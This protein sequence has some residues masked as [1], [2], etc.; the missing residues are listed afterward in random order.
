[1]ADEKEKCPVTPAIRVLKAAAA[2][3]AGML[4]DY[5]ERA[6][7]TRIAEVFGVDEHQVIKTLVLET[8]GKKPLVVLMHGDRSVSLKEL[9]RFLG[10]KGVAPCDPE[11]AE[12]HSGYKC[13]GTSPFGLR[14]AMPVYVEK[15][16]LA[17]DSIYINGGHR[18]FVLRLPVSE[19]VRIVRPTPVEVAIDSLD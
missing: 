14:K 10:V 5:V 4:Y 1:M 6:G 12:R 2:T 3:Y 8:D 16:I 13:G 7:T 15:S 18:G 11:Q 9:A 17:M 19:L